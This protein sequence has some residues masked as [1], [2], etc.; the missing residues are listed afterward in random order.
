MKRHSE[1]QT[2]YLTDTLAYFTGE[3]KALLFR[4][5]KQVAKHGQQDK[6][7]FHPLPGKPFLPC[8]IRLRGQAFP[9]FLKVRYS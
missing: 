1:V 4:P 8:M 6:Q 3:R 9:L 5:S 2:Y 7:R